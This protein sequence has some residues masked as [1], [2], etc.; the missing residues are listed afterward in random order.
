MTCDSDTLCVMFP[1]CVTS[2]ATSP[3]QESAIKKGKWIKWRD[4]PEKA[5]SSRSNGLDKPELELGVEESF[6]LGCLVSANL[7][8]HESDNVPDLDNY[9]VVSGCLCIS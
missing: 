4:N 5:D 7:I 1:P 9:G 6:L 2:T 3:A 8:K